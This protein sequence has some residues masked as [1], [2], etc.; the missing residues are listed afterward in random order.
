MKMKLSVFG[1]LLCLFVTL[2]FLLFKKP[3]KSNALT[4]LQKAVGEER[5]QDEPAADYIE[6]RTRYEFD[7]LKDPQTGEI[8]AGIFEQE[9]AFARSLPVRTYDVLTNS[10][11][12]TTALNTYIPAGPNNVG[13]RTRAILY[14]RRY[15]GTT[16]RIV[17]AGCVSGGIMRSADGGNSWS[18]VSPENEIHNLTSLAQDPNNP[19][20]WY[21]GGGEPLGNSATEIGAS[22]MGFGI[23]KSTN[24]GVSWTRLPLNTITTIDGSGLLAAG[25]LE[26]FDHPFDFVHKIAVNPVN[27][28][29]YIAGHRRLVKS[30]DGGA[31]FRVVFESNTSALS[32]NGQ[33]DIAIANTGMLYLAVNGG[34]ALDK[35]GVWVSST[36]SVNTW[37]RIAGGQTLGADSVAGWRGGSYSVVSAGPP[38]QY[39]SKRILVTLAPSNNNVAY[40]YYEN[41]LSS[42]APGLQPEADLF[43][44]DISGNTYTWTNRS[45]NLP[46]FTGGNLTGSDPLSVQG[47]YDMEIVV[48]PDNPNVVFISGTNLYRSTDG[49]ATTANTAWIGGYS[50]NFT[51]A[52]YA[53]SHS[54]VHRLT[55]SPSNANQAICGNDG[56]IQ[57]T[58]DITAASVSWTVLPNYQTLQCYNVAIDPGAG[59]NNFAAGAQDNGIRFRD[60]T[61]VFG[62]AAADSNNHVQL[63]SADGAYV[64]IT[65][66]N[67]G[68]QYLFESIQLG[69]LYR[70]SLTSPFAQTEVTPANLTSNGTGT[71]NQFGEFVTNLRLESDN[72][73]NLYYVNFNRL[74]RTTSAST[75]T[76]STWTELTGVSAAVNS[77]NNSTSGR[78]I[79]G[80]GYSRGPYTSSHVL[81]FGTT[82]G[83]IFRLDDPQNTAPATVPLNITPAGLTGNVQDIATNPNNDD[84]VIAVVS[85]YGVVGIWWTKNGKS[86]SP[87]WKNAEGNLTLPS[88][89]SCAIVVKKDAGNQPV[90]EYYVGTSVGLYSTVNLGT[91]LDGNGSPIWQREGENVLNY[92]VITSIAYR[93]LD[94]VM[95]LGTHGNGMY[96]TNIGTTNFTPNVN[97]GIITV[98]NDRNFIRT[99][100]P[101][102]SANNVQYQIGNMSGVKK[103]SVQLLNMTGQLVYKEEKG[104]QSGGVPL[105]GLASGVYVL[106]VTSDD[107]KYRHVQKIIKQ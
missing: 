18:R 31:T 96:Y 87:A 71:T 43:R 60:R 55:F 37:T 107:N 65:G 99:V 53:N 70:R 85:N 105:Q 34:A 22:Y 100:Y 90:T 7:M 76:S 10:Q 20:T 32:S 11:F 21:A 66:Q 81:Y 42:D 24:D 58:T 48:K 54:D 83:R 82:D 51:Y 23:Y 84:E 67:A 14:D 78:F 47:G 8:P 57:E 106:Q 59:R 72:S 41:G 73:D 77:A 45:A 30:T 27:S 28:D 6:A 9:K 38:V 35:R 102:V 79:R 12:K 94:N 3:F 44:L 104:Y 97:T 49:F 64:G 25:V 36:G 80:I 68:A 69:R 13:G 16:N 26:T 29:L 95:L 91:V 2:S 19:D 89:R 50:T 93:P 33:M 39:S 86:A 5:E 40:V 4:P 52:Q 75:V 92:A 46:D 56:G 98:T 74:F 1:V 15:N 103:I 101:T 62:T 88:F 61:G 17:L 63:F